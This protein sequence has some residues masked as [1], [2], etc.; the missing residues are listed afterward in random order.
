[1]DNNYITPERIRNITIMNSE[2]CNLKCEY[3]GIAKT[4]INKG[5]NKLIKQ[6]YKNG[7][8]VKNIVDTFDK[9][10]VPKENI[11]SLD[12]WGQEPTLT[13]LEFA[14]EFK[15]FYKNFPNIQNMVMSTNGMAF[16]ERIVN[17]I[18]TLEN[19]VTKPLYISLQFSNDGKYATDMIRKGKFETI[20]KNYQEVIKGLGEIELKQVYVGMHFHGVISIEL[21]KKLANATD[22]EIY[23]YWNWGPL[24]NE[25][26]S[27]NKNPNVMV[28]CWGPALEFPVNASKEEG[29]LL[30]LFIKRSIEIFDKTDFTPYT[31]L[32]APYDHYY[33]EGILNLYNGIKPTLNNVI[34]NLAYYL[35]SNNKPDYIHNLSNGIFCG[36]YKGSLRFKYDGTMVHCHNVIHLT[37]EENCEKLGD[38]QEYLTAKYLAKHGYYVN[39]LND[40][41]EDESKINYKRFYSSEISS[42][43]SFASVYTTTVNLMKILRDANQIHESYKDDKKLLRHSFFAVYISNCYDS[44]LRDNGAVISK[45][46]GNLRFL[47]N[48]YMDY[49]EKFLNLDAI[50]YDKIEEERK[51]N[52][53]KTRKERGRPF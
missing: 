47:C 3:C 28:G 29:E 16:P 18:Q 51:N 17:L 11:T 19:T 32:F 45:Q 6:S 14:D 22:K 38:D 43:K 7:T 46:V 40:F 37:K 21:I 30:A 50:D 23:D 20:V 25:C 2:E 5:Q 15:N 33:T 31:I 34:Y 24:L 48:G 13:L 12:L 42:N 35:N 27:F 8:F 10:N 26:K 36:P 9:L 52:T 53:K 39:Y 41:K 1:M 44:S 49:V 4:E